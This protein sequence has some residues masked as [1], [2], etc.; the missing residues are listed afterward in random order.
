MSLLKIALFVL[1]FGMSP[2]QP[3]F[4]AQQDD[5]GEKIALMGSL[6]VPDRSTSVP[7]QATIDGNILQIDFNADLGSVSIVVSGASGTL[8]NNTVSAYEGGNVQISLAGAAAGSY[9]LMVSSSYGNLSGCF[10]I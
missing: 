1:C 2:M 10:S 4:V 8:Y 9:T 7:V 5:P 6:S 3:N